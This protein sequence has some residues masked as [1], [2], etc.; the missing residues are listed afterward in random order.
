MS[1]NKIKSWRNDGYAKVTGRAK[2]ADDIKYV[3]MLH[4]VPVYTD[5]VH[6]KIKNINTEQAEKAE[7]VIAVI[8]AKD[9]PGS[10]R[11]GQIDK[12]YYMFAHDKIRG[13]GDVV[14]MI[15][16]ETR[17][18]AIEAI[19]KVVVIG[20]ELPVVL[21]P[22]EAMKSDSALVHEEKK[23]NLV[24][25][26]VVRRGS[27]DAGF[28]SSDKIFEREYQ[29]QYIEHAY[30]EP[31]SAVCNPRHD[32][33]M[34]IHGS[35]QHPFSTRKFVA[36]L[37][38]KEL[39][40]IEVIGTPMGGGFG[41]KDDTAAIVC[42]RTALASLIT[43]HPVKMTYKREW[44][45]RESYKRHPYKMNYKVGVSDAGKINSVECRIIADAGNY[46]SVTP[47]VLW[48]ST[49]QCCGPYKVDNVK[50]DG[51]GVH[52][53]NV[54]TGAMRGFGSPQV[55]FAVESLVEEIAE[56]LNMS[57]LD[58]RKLNMVKQGDE[59][60]TGQ[61]LDGHS[62]NMEKVLDIVSNEIDYENKLKKCSR[63]VSDSDELY[64]IGL[65]MSYR[66]MSLGAEGKDFCS[67]IINAQPD[68]SVLLET[69][70]HENGQGLESAMIL[71]LAEQLGIK[72]ERI[73]YQC[74]S[75]S[76]IPD[77][78]TTVASRGTIMG[79]GAVTKA[80]ENFKSLITETLSKQFDASQ[81]DFVFEN[82]NVI[83]K[84]K[85]YTFE[86]IIKLMFAHKT[87]PFA[88]GLFQGPEVSWDEKTGK[89]NAYFTWV[90]SCQAVELIVDKKKGKVKLLNA[91]A[92]HDV[93]KAINP[94]MVLGQIYGGM[95]MGMGYGLR[96]EVKHKE[97]K[98]RSTNFHK[99]HLTRA[100][101]VP[102]MKGVIVESFD[103]LS[104]SGAKGVGEPTNE[105]MA[106]AIAN[107]VY[108]ATGK[109]YYKLPIKIEI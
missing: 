104:P 55:N 108:N 58:F 50:Y 16:A 62:V 109:R 29:T 97:G 106:P 37:L 30:M 81:E 80:A 60:I 100:K 84:E 40:E 95:V 3:N 85:K 70:V 63:G 28:K 96:E 9:V 13:N 20:E 79:G 83:I 51:Y 18:Q 14:A 23:T 2:Y 35:M 66:G 42:A 34:E 25:H 22:E 72:K 41:G 75:T 68:G 103:S 31:E 33:V 39:S 105:I 52:T 69:G 15:V 21:D 74:S 71:I 65:A 88:Y 12:D 5:Y 54:F 67:A 43:K 47:W 98:I 19:D 87:Y 57:S 76:T 56:E 61:I 6:A 38:G 4:A 11:Y 59:T 17:Q 10:N 64:G 99:Y 102:E 89:G 82:D 94:S 48:R 26:H 24:V 90:Y 53:N 92:A 1:E 45:I 44:S 91:V 107:A 32:G 77:G 49:V 78:G 46:T 7:G 101:D 93:G 73:R 36:A 27:V 8:T 86:E